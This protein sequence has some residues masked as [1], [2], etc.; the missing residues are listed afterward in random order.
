M[1]DESARTLLRAGVTGVVFLASVLTLMAQGTSNGTLVGLVTDTSGGVLP[2]VKVVATNVATNVEYPTVTNSTGN[3]TIPSLPIGTYRVTAELTGFK[4]MVYDN[5]LLEVNQTRRLDITMEVGAVTS[6]TTVT[7]QAA[8]VNTENATVGEVV[9]KQEIVDLPLNGRNFAELAQLTPG[10]VPGGRGF[11]GDE[12]LSGY[13]SPN[14]YAGGR[15]VN[16]SFLVDGIET[17]GVQF[18]NIVLVPNLDSIS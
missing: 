8:L 2:S 3:Y 18:G 16:N 10:T 15:N 5:V 11:G 13:N 6:S 4:R 12:D 1:K 7:A 14:F 17:K 9:E